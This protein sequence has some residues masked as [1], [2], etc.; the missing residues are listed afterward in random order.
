MLLTTKGKS[1][2]PKPNYHNSPF[3]THQPRW[4]LLGTDCQLEFTHMF[5][6]KCVRYLL[7]LVNP[8]SGC[9]RAVPTTNKRAQ[10]VSKLLLD[11]IPCF[12]IL[13]SVQLDIG[14]NL[15]PIFTKPKELT[16]LGLSVFHT[17][18]FSQERYN[19]LIAHL[20]TPL[21]NCHKKLT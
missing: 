8:F 16:T 15:Q 19:D 21:S 20:K 11:I 17:I 5:A 9:W 2:D 7:V 13:I 10:T 4:S 6:V 12:G 3:P 14:Q 1:T 18:H